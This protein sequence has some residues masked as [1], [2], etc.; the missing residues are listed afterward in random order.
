MTPDVVIG[1]SQIA[2]ILGIDRFQTAEQLF[3]RMLGLEPREPENEHMVRGQMLEDGLCRWW[4]HLARAERRETQHRSAGR[5]LDNGQLQVRHPELPWA[6]ATPDL[7]ALGYP[8][9]SSDSDGM[10]L[11]VD[12]KCPNSGRVKV[13]EQW[14]ASWSEATQTA[15][16]GYVVQSIYQQGVLRAAGVPVEAGELAA[17]PLWGRLERVAVPFDAELFALTLTRATAFRACVLAGVLTD[18]FKGEQNNV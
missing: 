4:A 17:G 5:I 15:P 13:G 10:L 8:V 3:R 14:V 11:A 12:V 1:A 16:R 7:I 18:D 9:G 2:A 6:R